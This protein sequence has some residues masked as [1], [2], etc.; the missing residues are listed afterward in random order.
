MRRMNRHELLDAVKLRLSCEVLARFPI[1]QIR[2]HARANLIRWRSQG[3]WSATYD[4]WLTIIESAD[5][6]LLIT[7]MSSLDEDSVRLRQSIPYVGMLDQS[8]VQKIKD[9]I[10]K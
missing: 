8:T 1:S 7:R 3:S 10:L 5:D 6:S 2:A 4:E 9:E